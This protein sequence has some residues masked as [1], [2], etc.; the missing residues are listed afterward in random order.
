MASVIQTVYNKVQEEALYADM[1][2][3][4]SLFLYMTPAILVVGIVGLLLLPLPLWIVGISVLPLLVMAGFTPYVIIRMTAEKRRE[5]IEQVLPDALLL[6]SANI[7]SGLTVDKALLVSARDEFGPLARE[8]KEASMEIFGGAPVEKA[9]RK[10]RDR[11]NS[12]LFRE[13]IRLI[14]DGMQAGGELSELLESSA[15]DIRKTLMLR[16]EISSNVKMYVLF[17]TMAAVVGAPLLFGISTYL[18][19]TTF[20]MWSEQDVDFSETK[21]SI[22]S[23]SQPTI[24]PKF[25]LRFAVTSIVV[26]NTFAS[27]I[28]SEIKHGTIVRGFKGIPIYLVISLAVF[29]AI[30]AGVEAMVG[31]L[32][33]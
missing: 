9:L 21:T 14:L 5:E 22:V 16:K 4:S 25:F 10:L 15:H 28:I 27:L 17:I 11:S 2:Q 26:T 29:F 20:T 30:R 18:I 12:G 24:D 23:I 3:P 7:R 6:M 33:G 13:V 31:G 32:I 8:V 1:E 19:D